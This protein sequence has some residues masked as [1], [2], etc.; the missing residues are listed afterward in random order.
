MI[1]ADWAEP[2]AANE[3]A[4]MHRFE[5]GA[6]LKVGGGRILL[7]RRGGGSPAP[8]SVALAVVE[9]ETRRHTVY[10]SAVEARFLAAQL[11]G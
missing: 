4:A 3:N 11:A 1:E 7:V 8:G 6:H 10:L 2:V 9:G 5:E